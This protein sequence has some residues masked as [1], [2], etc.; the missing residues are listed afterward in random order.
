MTFADWDEEIGKSLSQFIES[1]SSLIDLEDGPAGLSRFMQISCRPT[2]VD[3]H[4]TY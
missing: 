1:S 3:L 4:D 2:L